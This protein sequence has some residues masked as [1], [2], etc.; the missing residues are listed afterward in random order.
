[1]IENPRPTRAEV[2][3]VASAIYMRT[4]AVMLSGETAYGKYP[5][6]AIRTMGRIACE[7]EPDRDKRYD[8]LI[9]PLKN[10]IPAY[11]AQS[12]IRAAKE[13]KPKAIVTSTTTGKTARY[14]A[15]Y[16]SIFPVYA[17]CHSQRVV[18]EMALSFGIHA[19]YLELQKNKMKIQKAAILQLIEDE[20]LKP[21]DMVVYVGGRFGVESN[22]SFIEVS[23]A[24]KLI[25]KPKEFR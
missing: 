5:A 13:L 11:L 3:D 19:S 8:I 4:D 10:E 20:L 6:E 17:Q 15:A 1:M 16:R 21:E 24:E 2:S 22:A 9:P 12:A 23:T 18:R 7:V 25:V 14:L